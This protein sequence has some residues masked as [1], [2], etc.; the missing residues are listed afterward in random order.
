MALVSAFCVC[1]YKKKIMQYKI[2]EAEEQELKRLKEQDS[3]H[4]ELQQRRYHLS[5]VKRMNK[6][7][8]KDMHVKR[9]DLID[10]YQR[11]IEERIKSSSKKGKQKAPTDKSQ[12]SWNFFRKGDSS[13][14][15]YFGHATNALDVSSSSIGYA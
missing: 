9:K 13:L 12:K 15:D 1:C 3:I 10:E 11:E 2:S 7:M 14:T 6:I 8:M 5:Q 4:L